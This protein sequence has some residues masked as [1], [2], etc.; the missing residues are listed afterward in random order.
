M[1][2]TIQENIADLLL[3]IK[4]NQEKEKKERTLKNYQEELKSF[5]KKLYK[6]LEKSENVTYLKNLE[7]LE[8]IE[9][10]VN[11]GF[12]EVN[13]QHKKTDNS[14]NTYELS[15]KLASDY[16]SY[17]LKNKDHLDIHIEQL[18]EPEFPYQREILIDTVKELKNKNIP[19]ELIYDDTTQEEVH[20]MH[21]EI[22]SNYIK[23]YQEEINRQREKTGPRVIMPEDKKSFMLPLLISDNSPKERKET[24]KKLFSEKL[25]ELASD[26]SNVGLKN[27]FNF[28]RDRLPSFISSMAVRLETWNN[29]EQS[30]TNSIEIAFQSSSFLGENG[31]NPRVDLF[32][33]VQP[34]VTVSDSE[35]RHFNTP[36]SLAQTFKDNQDTQEKN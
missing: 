35:M 23:E 30:L 5:Q 22:N 8:K 6:L 18:Y 16:Q 27:R 31:D 2:K 17:I 10:E 34:T 4:E 1:S 15:E 12:I 20:K 19:I 36:I 3:Q 13:K 29:I 24:V 26:P 32:S 21:I 11:A 14:L 25:S 7:S 9:K 28:F 33:G